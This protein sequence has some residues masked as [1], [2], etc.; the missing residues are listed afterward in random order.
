M[1]AAIAVAGLLAGCGGTT[2][3]NDSGEEF[4]G[5]QRLVANTVE[6]LQTAASEADEDK[7]CRD[8]LARALTDRL[9]ARG[10]GCP[11]VVDEAVRDADTFDLTVES[12]RITGERA[13]ARVRAETGDKDR[14]YS[15]QLVRERGAWRIA[16]L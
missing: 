6:D 3:G 2:A 4:Q 14:R 10:R 12:V 11:P 16:E 13:T 8:I 15:L 9:A 5:Q 1:F 7:I